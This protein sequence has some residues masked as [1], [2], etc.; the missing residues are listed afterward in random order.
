VVSDNP[1]AASSRRALLKLAGDTTAAAIAGCGSGSSSKTHTRTQP[2][3]ANQVD[4]QLL[5]SALD[6]EYRAIA[7]YTAAVPVL[8]GR[9]HAA[10]KLFLEQELAHAST[11]MGYIALA[12]GKPHKQRSSYDFGHPRGARGIFAVAARL[13]Q[14]Q[15]ANYLNAVTQLSLP[16]MRAAVASVLAN[17]AQHLSVAMLTLGRNPISSAFV[18]GVG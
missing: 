4:I 16:R 18:T 11:M 13:E 14:A 7:L 15:I 8:S 12:G 6:L 5:N 17:D 10:A 2:S 1:G 3:P 9:A